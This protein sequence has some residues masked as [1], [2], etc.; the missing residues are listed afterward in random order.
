MITSAHAATAAEPA[1]STE[2]AIVP[3]R[4]SQV[5]Q[6]VYAAVFA[7]GGV[8]LTLT[9]EG[10][11][12]AIGVLAV[13][14]AV[15]AL[16]AF[17][18]RF[19]SRASIVLSPAGLRLPLGGEIP[20]QD[21]GDVGL[22]EYKR[23]TLVGLRLRSTERF[24]G[25]FTDEERA[26]LARNAKRLRMFSRTTA[27]A[28]LGTFDASD[29]GG[30]D[31]LIDEDRKS[32]NAIAGDASLAT[33]AGTIAFARKHFGYDWTIGALELDRSPAQFVALLDEHRARSAT[34]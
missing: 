25:S 13:V 16:L 12:R 17:R 6:A 20:W 27:A 7:A 11:E 34:A 29:P 28:Q 22:I 10:A 5:K 30:Y 31:V 18:Q 4:R 32:L 33:V 24:I 21:L 15:W 19:R 1:E 2:H 26:A 3:S 9:G 23:A 8:Y 14:F